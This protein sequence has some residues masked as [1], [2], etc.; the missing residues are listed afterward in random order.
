[1]ETQFP[2]LHPTIP[3]QVGK[4]RGLFLK[5]RRK[6]T[7]RREESEGAG[8]VGETWHKLMSFLVP[9][10]PVRGVKNIVADDDVVEL[11]EDIVDLVN[12][13]AISPIAPSIRVASITYVPLHFNFT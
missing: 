11:Y 10:K 3:T 8:G 4:A 12:T 2:T 6:V 7:I 1:M 9:A 13:P 5:W